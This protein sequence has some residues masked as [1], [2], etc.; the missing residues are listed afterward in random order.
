MEIKI[1]NINQKIERG[2]KWFYFGDSY[3]QLSYLKKKLGE[4]NFLDFSIEKDNIFEFELNDYLIWTEKNRIKFND[5]LYWWST[6]LAGK[7]NLN[8]S[9]FR[10]ICG[11][12]F[13]L[14]KI[15]ENKYDK[16]NIICD[17]IFVKK[18]LETNLNIK[19]NFL[20]NYFLIIRKIANILFKF[21]LNIIKLLIKYFVMKIFL[22][23]NKNRLNLKNIDYIFNTSSI[24]FNTKKGISLPY[25][26]GIDLTKKKS[27]FFYLSKKNIIEKLK[28]I[29][30]Y[31]RNNVIISERFINPFDLI[32]IYYNFLKVSL[33]FFKLLDYKKLDLKYFI[34]LELEKYL[35][36]PDLNFQIWSYIPTLKKISKI[37]KILKVFDHYENM[38]SEHVMIYAFRKYFKESFIYGYHHTFSSKQFLCWRHIESE[39]ESNFKPDYIISSCKLSKNFLISQNCPEKRI[40]LGPA[41]RYKNLINQKNNNLTESTD[42]VTV[43]LS[44]IKDHSMEVIEKVYEIFKINKN[45]KFKICPHPNL[46]LDDRTLNKYFKKDDKFQISK[47]NLKDTLIDSKFVI[48]SATGAIYDSIILKKIFFNL[49]S[50]LNFCDNYADFMTEKYPFLRTYKAGEISEYLQKSLKDKA[51]LSELSKQYADLSNYFINN[52]Q[53]DKDFIKITN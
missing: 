49:R 14:N 23:L 1:F 19:N 52:L 10:N 11:L 35:K 8:S 22:L 20:S 41:L 18:G 26:P 45:I 17:N 6:E 50:D 27:I 36:T 28:A 51:Y 34:Y 53:C 40:I 13:I 15:K 7:N 2:I 33:I 25:F 9:L 39:W 48:S 42:C 47:K 16:L 5:S 43:P 38:G 46:N 3:E 4:E 32:I 12:N 29:S 24:K 30:L 37:S 31:E 21:F 44:Q